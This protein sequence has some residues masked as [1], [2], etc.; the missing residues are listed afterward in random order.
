MLPTTLMPKVQMVIKIMALKMLMAS[1][2]VCLMMMMS[3]LMGQLAS[4]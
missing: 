1:L 2:F 3:Y 4:V